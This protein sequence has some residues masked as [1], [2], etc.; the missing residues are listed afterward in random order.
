MKKFDHQCSCVCVYVC[1]VL[2]VCVC[3]KAWVLGLFLFYGLEKTVVVELRW[4][5]Q[6]GIEKKDT[7]KKELKLN[8][9]GNG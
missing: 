6:K 8:E 9:I 3:S 7:K 1:C 4:R 5:K 2:R